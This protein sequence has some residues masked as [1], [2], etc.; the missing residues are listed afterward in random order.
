[1]IVW[2][3][4]KVHLATLIA[5]Q[6]F[7]F[8]APA[9]K[10][11]GLQELAGCIRSRLSPDAQNR[12]FAKIERCIQI[13]DTT[14]LALY[15]QGPQFQEGNLEVVCVG[16]KPYT[17]ERGLLGRT[18]GMEETMIIYVLKVTKL[19]FPNAI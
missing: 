16:A 2:I 13:L 6:C 12:A 3:N 9:A 7:G 15:F 18:E 14:L 17:C 19:E 4:F 1:M 11:T 10:V 5:L 8:W